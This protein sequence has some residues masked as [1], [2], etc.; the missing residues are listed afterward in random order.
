MQVDRNRRQGRGRET[1]HRHSGFQGYQQARAE[2]QGEVTQAGAE[3]PIS[4]VEPCRGQQHQ[5]RQVMRSVCH[6]PPNNINQQHSAAEAV[7]NSTE[8]VWLPVRPCGT[9]GRAAGS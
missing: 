6:P 2:G 3:V 7:A 9:S 5:A 8:A 4:R 1:D